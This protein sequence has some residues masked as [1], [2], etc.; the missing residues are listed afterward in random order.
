MFKH[1][2]VLSDEVLKNFESLE[3]GEMIVDGTLGRG[4]HCKILLENGFKVIGIDRDK[5]AVSEV[6]KNL[7]EF[8]GLEIVHNNFSEIKQVLLKFSQYLLSKF[9]VVRKVHK[10]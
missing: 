6:R 3:K 5:E 10:V 9:L 7:K 2:P 1:I 4:G 8:N